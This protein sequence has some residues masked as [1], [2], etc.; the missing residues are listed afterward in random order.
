M[1][2]ILVGKRTEGTLKDT[3]TSSSSWTAR[4]PV[5][6]IVG[7]LATFLAF[8]VVL[9]SV[10]TQLRQPEQR[11]LILFWVG[12]ALVW[13]LSILSKSYRWLAIA[14]GVMSVVVVVTLVIGL[15]LRGG[16]TSP[17]QAVGRATYL[18]ISV[19]TNLRAIFLIYLAGALLGLVT[20]LVGRQ[21]RG[22]RPTHAVQQ[23]AMEPPLGAPATSRVEQR[24]RKKRAARRMRAERAILVAILF[25]AAIAAYTP[26]LRSLL[27][28]AATQQYVPSWDGDNLLA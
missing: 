25:I 18:G 4:I 2:D 22:A 12:F 6:G 14:V 19:S 5:R 24:G 9:P 16:L 8:G 23:A 20:A 28:V 17:T 3:S 27:H 13:L 10:I 21:I 1:T 26:D 7:A 11:L 15:R